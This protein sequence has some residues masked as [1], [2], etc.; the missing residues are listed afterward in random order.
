[1]NY[2]TTYLATQMLPNYFATLF[3]RGDMMVTPPFSEALLFFTSPSRRKVLASSL[4]DATCDQGA[5]P[6]ESLRK[7]YRKP[8]KCGIFYG[9]L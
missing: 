3:N 7:A 6:R 9:D 1:M 4:E 5:A 8:G 2:L